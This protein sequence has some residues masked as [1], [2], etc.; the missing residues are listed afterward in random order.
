MSFLID[1][2]DRQIFYSGSCL[3]KAITLFVPTCTEN[4]YWNII[5]RLLSGIPMTL[6]NRLWNNM[7]RSIW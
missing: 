6:F 1:N 5:A 3:L 7:D 4:Y 2:L